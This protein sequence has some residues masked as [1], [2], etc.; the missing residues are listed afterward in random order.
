MQPL[1]ISQTPISADAGDAS[2]VASTHPSRTNDVGFNDL[3]SA[4][5]A[6][7]EKRQVAEEEFAANRAA[8]RAKL[9]AEEKEA[10]SAVEAL[11]AAAKFASRNVKLKQ[12]A[13]EDERI[14]S[15]DEKR[16]IAR[17]SAFTQADAPSDT[18][19]TTDEKAVKSEASSRETLVEQPHVDAQTE[20]D[21]TSKVANI[22]TEESDPIA[23]TA[24]GDSPTVAENLRHPVTTHGPETNAPEVD[25]AED[26]STKFLA[27]QPTL[28]PKDQNGLTLNTARANIGQS[29]GDITTVQSGAVLATLT[30]AA[31]ETASTAAKA[32]VETTKAEQPHQDPGQTAVGFE[33]ADAEKNRVISVDLISNDTDH[34]KTEASYVANLNTTTLTN[35]P[36][37]ANYDKDQVLSQ[38]REQT[39]DQTFNR[40]RPAPAIQAPNQGDSDVPSTAQRSLVEP[41]QKLISRSSLT[42][43]DVH[44][45][46]KFAIGTKE[47]SGQD[48]DSPNSGFDDTSMNNGDEAATQQQMT[49]KRSSVIQQLKTLTEST[50]AAQNPVSG[51]NTVSVQE[52]AKLGVTEAAIG[53]GHIALADPE[54]KEPNIASPP[55]ATTITQPQIQN[56]G[57][58]ASNSA[59]NLERRTIAADIRLRALERMV[60]AAARAGTESITLQLYP[61]GLG[62]VMIRLVMDGQK[63]RIM[64]RAANAEAVDALKDMEGDLRAALAGDG[65]VLT[66]FDVTDEKQ[67]GEQDRREKSAETAAQSSGRSNESFTVDLNA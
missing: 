36:A 44:K 20:A 13:A 60:V 47:T 18:E 23:L 15:A 21:K 37:P 26:L 59:S 8:E 67:N 45:V 12:R 40:N 58:E 9:Q 5:R 1:A 6:I 64:T 39:P 34:Q 53:G 66:T 10:E 61:P 4:A 19:I 49:D 57:T 22:D 62:Q 52:L 27:Q 63:L 29:E 50:S 33:N 41:E 7:A 46:T 43:I 17:S 3:F 51:K 30:G 16:T 25:P 24:K 32:G 55:L 31:T 56:G 28:V 14:R 11:T 38:G 48:F 35:S 65:L 54:A 42:E 2:N